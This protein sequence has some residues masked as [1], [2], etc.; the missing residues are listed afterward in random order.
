M[1]KM[2]KTKK[3][4]GWWQRGNKTIMQTAQQHSYSTWRISYSKWQEY[5]ITKANSSAI[6]S[7]LTWEKIINEISS[8]ASRI[9]FSQIDILIHQLEVAVKYL[10]K[11]ARV[12]TGVSRCPTSSSIHLKICWLLAARKK[13]MSNQMR[14]VS[15]ERM[16]MK[17]QKEGS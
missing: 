12:I 13:S 6:N 14:K 3:R 1:Q 11:K 4:K 8:P 15:R 9:T 17:M 10:L 7:P 2:N 16:K 5:T